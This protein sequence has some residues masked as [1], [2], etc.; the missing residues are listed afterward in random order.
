MRDRVEAVVYYDTCGVGVHLPDALI[1]DLHAV[2]E[3]CR[4]EDLFRQKFITLIKVRY[5]YGSRTSLVD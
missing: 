1:A 3:I 5:S 4:R 2:S